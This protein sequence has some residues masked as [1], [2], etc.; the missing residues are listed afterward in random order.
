[1]FL[2]YTYFILLGIVLLL[3]LIIALRPDKP[4]QPD[5]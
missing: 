2:Y 4:D 3:W 1:M 5:E